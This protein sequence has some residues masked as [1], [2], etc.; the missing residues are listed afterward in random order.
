[1]IIYLGNN[2]GRIKGAGARIP[3]KHPRSPWF[4]CASHDLNCVIVVGAQSHF[5]INMMED[6]KGAH[7]FLTGSAKRADHLASVIERLRDDIKKRKLKDLCRTRWAERH[8]AFET[9]IE[10]YDIVSSIQ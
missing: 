10:L 5:V 7:T 9:F 4:W 2:R 3:K 1:M 8:V 6:A